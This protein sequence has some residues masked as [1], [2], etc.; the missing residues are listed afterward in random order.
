MLAKAAEIDPADVSADTVVFLDQSDIPAQD[1][2][3]IET[4]RTLGIIQGNDGC[5]SPNRAVTRAE[6]AVMLMKM[7]GVLA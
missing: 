4:L 6:A 1:L 3:Y 2:G 5:F 7:L